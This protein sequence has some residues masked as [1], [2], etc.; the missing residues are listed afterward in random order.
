MIN[1]KEHYKMTIRFEYRYHIKKSLHNDRSLPYAS[2][3]N[4][5]DY[6]GK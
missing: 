3:M 2:Y 6:F 1:D 5:K 4:T